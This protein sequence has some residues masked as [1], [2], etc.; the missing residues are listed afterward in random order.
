MIYQI[1]F[2]SI[3]DTLYHGVNRTREIF[4]YFSTRLN[5]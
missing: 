5:N 1:R 3:F 4:C 2:N